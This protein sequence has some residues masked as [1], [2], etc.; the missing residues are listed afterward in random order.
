M[1]QPVWLT[2][3]GHLGTIPEGVFFQLPLLAEEPEFGDTVYFQVIA[4]QLPQGVQC[5]ATGLI[6]GVPKAIASIQGVPYEVN[7]DVTSKFAVRAYTKKVVNGVTVVDHVADRTFTITVTGPNVPEWVTPAGNIGTYFDGSQIAPLQLDFYDNDPN[8]EVVV[9]LVSGKLPAGLSVSP[10]GLIT[11]YIGL[12]ES[13]SNIAG[14]SRSGT[15]PWSK[16]GF[17][18]Q[19]RS[20][21]MTY[22]FVLSLTD[23]TNSNLRAFTIT[24]YSRN[25]LTADTI[26][27]TADNTFVTA[28]GTP[29][30]VPL[31]L[32]PEGSIG[33]TRSD[34]FYAFK[35]D[36]LDPSGDEFDYEVDTSGSYDI[37]PGVTLD[38]KTGWLYGYIPDLGLTELIYNFRVRVF[39][40]G[41]PGVVSDWYS[42]SLGVIGSIDTDV[43]WISPADLGY[44][45]TG[46]PSTFTIEAVNAADIPLLYRL[47][48]GSD[49]SLPQGLKL[50]PSG[51]IAGR[52]SFDV[53]MLDGNTTVFDVDHIGE[54]WVP[55]T[56]DRT[57]TFTVNA[58]SEDGLVS[59]FK[60]FNIKLDRVYDTQIG[61]AHV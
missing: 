31:I 59:V 55:T 49:S 50:L 21:N 6:I 28:D 24:V 40:R 46:S 16:F 19:T 34:N 33:T 20:V 44:I 10:T 12:A 56:F 25:N 9:K 57:F 54:T 47:S 3:A 14:W 11:G 17:D 30:R 51:N 18:F 23:G 15:Q 36:G 52:V 8:D 5:E 41:E 29:V 45:D 2:P 61:R 27:I 37:P 35:F 53:F 39:Q 4:G 32:T 42:Y 60:T 13:N 58:Y 38:P 1:A 22:E 48:S 43:T 7:E 26:D